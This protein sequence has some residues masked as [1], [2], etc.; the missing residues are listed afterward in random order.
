MSLISSSSPSPHL[1]SLAE[2]ELHP[3]HKTT[4]QIFNRLHDAYPV[5][6]IFFFLSFIAV[7]SIVSASRSRNDP[8]TEYGPGGKPLPPRHKQDP[9]ATNP[10]LNLTRTQSLLFEWLAAAVCFT[11]VCNAINIVIHALFDRRDQW[12]CGQAMVVSN[13]QDWPD[14]TDN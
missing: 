1:G 14:H 13:S 10:S 2:R 12:W 3:S 6:L 8:V 5:T 7:R 11:F 9:S 4:E